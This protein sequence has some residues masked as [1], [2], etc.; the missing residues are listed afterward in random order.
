MFIPDWEYLLDHMGDPIISLIKLFMMLSVLMMYLRGIYYYY[1]KKRAEEFGSI[2]LQLKATTHLIGA[3]GFIPAVF[4]L[5]PSILTM[6]P[7]VTVTAL[8]Y[9]YWLKPDEYR[10][11]IYWSPKKSEE[12]MEIIKLMTKE[13]HEQWYKDYLAKAPKCIPVRYFI[14]SEVICY[15]LGVGLT[16]YIGRL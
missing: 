9:Q 3:F 12:Q 6:L 4:P 8:T 1:I 13:E 7:L 11:N 10:G 5:V 2:R 14:I 15:L 16:Y